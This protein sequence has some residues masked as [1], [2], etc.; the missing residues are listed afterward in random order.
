MTLKTYKTQH[1]KTKQT[2]GPV[3]NQLSASQTGDKDSHNTVIFKLLY[4]EIFHNKR[5]RKY[6]RIQYFCLNAL[7]T[8]TTHEHRGQQSGEQ[9]QSRCGTPSLTL[10]TPTDST[11]W[12]LAPLPSFGGILPHVPGAVSP[13]VQSS[14]LS[15]DILLHLWFS[16]GFAYGQRYSISHCEMSQWCVSFL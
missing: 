6:R 2:W 10:P 13:C 15:G 9:R 12:C 7:I 16:H 8:C 4:A 11:A 14:Q 3:S 5:F 1:G